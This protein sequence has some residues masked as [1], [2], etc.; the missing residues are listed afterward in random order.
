MNG[1]IWDISQR[2]RPDL[3]VWPG[4]TEFSQEQTWMMADGSPVN[5]ADRGQ[6]GKCAG[7]ERF[8]G[9]VAIH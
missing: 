5:V 2:L 8:I 4:D 7:R 6:T 9:A 3:P 1:R